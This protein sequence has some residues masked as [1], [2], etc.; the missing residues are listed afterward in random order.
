M[1]GASGEVLEA[2]DVGGRGCA[3]PC[4][5]QRELAGSEVLEHD[6]AEARGRS[7]GCV[8]ADAHVVAEDAGAGQGR[9][10]RAQRGIGH[11]DVHVGEHT[12]AQEQRRQ[13][14]IEVRG[15]SLPRAMREGADV[16]AEEHVRRRHEAVCGDACVFECMTEGW[17]RVYGGGFLR[18]RRGKVELDVPGEARVTQAPEARVAAGAE[19]DDLDARCGRV[20]APA[21]ASL[22]EV[23]YMCI[24][25]A[26]PQ[27]RADID[28][29]RTVRRLGMAPQHVGVGVRR[30]VSRSTRRQPGQERICVRRA[31]GVRLGPSVRPSEREARLA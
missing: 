22:D 20:G 10:A 30:Q 25:L 1:G 27:I 17:M 24:D 9:E 7:V 6:L 15:D 19:A 4:A 16:D 14:W 26:G 31:H 13:R 21:S 29:R 18:R 2:L 3:S 8:A 11:L 5:R 23:L 12:F 28:D